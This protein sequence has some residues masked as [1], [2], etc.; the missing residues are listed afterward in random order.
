[1][2]AFDMSI[3]GGRWVET[4]H[5]ARQ[6]IDYYL[7]SHRK[8]GGLGIDSETTGLD[9][10]RDSVI[11]WSL[12]D[13]E[14]R[15]CLD[16]KFIPL[17]KKPI[18]ENPE[19]NFDLTN[20]KF[21]MHMF[22]NSGAELVN[23]GELRDTVVMSWLKNE[24]NQ[25][26]HGLKECT[27]DYFGR[28]TPTFE[29]TFGKIPA[30]RVD[31]VTGRI[32]SKTVGQL[33][34][35]ALAD[36]DKC[37]SA[38]DYAS[39]DAYNSTQLRHCFDELLAGE[40][41]GWGSLKD[42]YYNFEV[43][44]TKVLWK[45]ERRGI[46]VDKGYLMSQQG[47]MEARMEQMKADF[48]RH[49]GEMMNLNSPMHVRKF[50]FDKL[51]KD[52]IKET[53]GGKGGVRQPSTDA[54]VLDV[55]AGQGDPW[56]QLLLD[57]RAVAKIYG[58]YITGLQEWIDSSYRIHTS[59]NQSG[60]VT[61]RLSS[62]DPNLQNLPRADEDEFKIREAFI[63]GERKR[64][65][66]CVAPNTRIL[67]TD[68]TWSRA[69][70]IKVGDWV[71]G[72]D[73]KLTDCKF[74]SSK[75]LDVEHQRRS[76]CRIVTDRGTVTSSL[77]HM[78][79]VRP[80]RGD[81]A[82]QRRWVATQ[83]LEPGDRIS[84]FV[85]PWDVDNSREAGYL[86][87]FFDGEG[88]LSSRAGTNG[89]TGT[90]VGF[91]QNRGPT[92]DHVLAML[93]ER[94][95]EVGETRAGTSCYKHWLRN[96]DTLR[97][98]GSVRPRRLLAKADEI[99]E[100]RRTWGRN[101]RPATILS[102]EKIGVQ[103]VVAIRTST[104]TFI[105]EGMLSHNCDY[106]QLE[107]RLMAHF[108]CD[109]K[110]I[111]AIKQGKD[112][113]CFTTAEME[114]IPYDDVLKAKKKEKKD[115][116]E[117]DKELLLKRQNN[118]STGF[119]IIYGIGGPKL[120]AKLTRETKHLVTNEEGARLINKW[121]DVFPG[122][123]SYIENTKARMR[124][125]GYVQVVTGRKRRFGDIMRMSNKDAAQAER[126][127]VNAIIQGTAAECAK[128]AMIQ[129]EGDSE[130]K[131]LGVEMLL[132]VHDELVLEVPDDP[133]ICE[134]ATKRVKQIMEHPLNYEFYVPLPASGGV[135]ESWAAAK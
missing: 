22:A 49:N 57:Y 24:N 130:L 135:A 73:E 112:L 110:M 123:R 7:H 52:V 38:V 120:A 92:R 60:T 83:D 5:E 42:Y 28:V 1:M 13:G 19:I 20:A 70:D 93:T 72:F 39:L 17:F 65:L 109:E 126:Q 91:A 43:P 88:W 68:L 64:L 95:Y 74:Q 25:G 48:N 119:G 84:F 27:V 44:F 113:H 50:F 117:H 16:R 10:I 29:Q 79:V 86:A 58:T 85:N 32:L 23:A 98:L 96:G 81:K 33:I 67:K 87:G 75:V 94:G 105:A 61:G 82:S 108:S 36:A 15:I 34:R 99:W 12:S 46:T 124:E 134:A 55:W 97:F 62:N 118:K 102:V 3:P 53:K 89:R 133:E 76:C 45:M 69:D 6:W 56:A 78:W 4:E 80:A 26:R 63:G 90:I 41:I 125:L 116:T 107:M 122:V 35:E 9:K 131:R 100:G 71:I 121:L 66:V 132:Q 21:D 114:G 40:N 59:L 104:H 103:P 51:K 115:Q 8:N 11:I 54:E 101:N 77:E 14:T 106:E 18:L 127:G 30:K 47:P 128:C 2:F 129:V 111:E 37:I 31:K